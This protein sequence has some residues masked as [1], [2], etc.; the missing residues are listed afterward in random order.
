MYKHKQK[1]FQILTIFQA[2]Q[3]FCL[4]GPECKS[5]TARAWRISKHLAEHTT[6]GNLALPSLSDV[7][8]APPGLGSSPFWLHIG[9]MTFPLQLE[10]QIHYVIFIF[11][12]KPLFSRISYASLS[13]MSHMSLSLAHDLL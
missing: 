6:M 5:V 11:I 7:V 10:Q 2:M 1:W 12:Y 4:P 8:I 13:P 9:A 3:C